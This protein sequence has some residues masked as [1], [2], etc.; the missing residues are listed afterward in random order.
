M[1]KKDRSAVFGCNK[2]PLSEEKY[3]VKF[4]FTRKARVNTERV[5]RGHPIILLYSNKFNVAAVSVKKVYCEDR[6]EI[7]FCD[8]PCET[9]I[10]CD[11]IYF[12]KRKFAFFPLKSLWHI[13]YSDDIFL[14]LSFAISIT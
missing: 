14:C 5:P 6:Y 4:F 2:D 3:T 7:R 1:G 9:L 10:P 11:T 12:T 13:F 8:H